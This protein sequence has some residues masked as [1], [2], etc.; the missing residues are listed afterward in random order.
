MQGRSTVGFASSL[1]CLLTRHFFTV[2]GSTIKIHS[3]SSG[4]VVSVLPRSRDKGHTDIITSATLSAQ[5]AFQLI[6]ASL[7]GT[8]KI[9]DFLEGNLL[10]TIDLAQPIHRICVHEKLKDQVFVS[11]DKLKKTQSTGVSLTL[12]RMF[13][14]LICFLAKSGSKPRQK[15]KAEEDTTL[16]LCISFDPLF[17]HGTTQVQKPSRVLRV[18]KTRETCGLAVSASGERL[19]AVAGHKAYVAKIA[20]LKSGFTKFVSPEALTCFAMHPSDEYFATGD[21]KGVIRLWHCPDPSQVNVVGV[22]KK[23]QTSTFHW[24]AHPVSSVAFTRNGAYLLSGGEEAV[25]VIWQLHSGKREFVPRVGAPIKDIVVSPPRESGEEY[26]LALTDSSYA[27][28]SAANLKLSRVFSGIKLGMCTPC[29]IERYLMRFQIFSHQRLHHRHPLPST[30]PPRLSSSHLHIPLHSRHTLLPLFLSSLSWRCHLLIG[31]PEEMKKC[32]SH[33][34]YNTPSY[35][36][37]GNG[38]PLSIAGRVTSTS[39]MKYILNSGTGTKRMH[40]GY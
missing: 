40:F 13:G 28:V 22:E 32:W 11:A 31:F 37:P 1:S 6:T 33:H 29:S 8:I 23:S 24:H 3:T 15:T 25:I 19:V 5:N 30:Y 35:P 14:R 9:W 7:D 39:E 38:W 12:S 26:L 18:G 36:L 4:K 2:V 10:C 16:V 21:V 17:S 20:D 34:E 27:F